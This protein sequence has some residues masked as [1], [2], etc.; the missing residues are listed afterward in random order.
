MWDGYV[1][2]LPCQIQN[3]KENGVLFPRPMVHWVLPAI[4]DKET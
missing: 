3:V 4:S 2:H 1:P